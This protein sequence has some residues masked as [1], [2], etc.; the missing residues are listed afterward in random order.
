M[1]TDSAMLL[2]PF[3]ILSAI[4]LMDSQAPDQSPLMICI[5]VLMIPNTTLM[6]V[7]T[8][9][10][11]VSQTVEITVEMLFHAVSMN[12]PRTFMTVVTTA[13]IAFQTVSAVCLINC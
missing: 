5:T 7:S 6:A 3:Q 1:N 9:V 12:G 11:M 4:P 2:I 13:E 8:T 10:L